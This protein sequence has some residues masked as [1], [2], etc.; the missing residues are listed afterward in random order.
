MVQGKRILLIIAGGIAAYKSLELIRRLGERG[1]SVRAI[2]TRAGAQFV[3]PL[4]VSSLTRERVFTDLFSLT[5]EAEI[6]HIELSRSADLIVVAPATADIMA[7]MATGLADDLAT[8]ALLATDKPVLIAPAMNVRMWT[9]PATQRNLSTLLQSNVT[10]VGPNDGDMACGEYG[11]GRMA[12]PEEIVAAIEALWG[13]RPS[14]SLK[15]C[16]VIITA[17][18]THEP[19]DPVR[20]IANRSSG[21]Q[22]YALAAAAIERGAETILIS[23]PTALPAPSGART[24]RVATAEE[25]QRAAEKELPADI[26]IFAAAVAD[27]RIANVSSEKIKKTGATKVPSLLLAENPDVLAHIAR[28]A[29]R[30]RLVVGFAAETENV[31]ANGKAKLKRKGADLIIANDVSAKSGVMGGTRNRVHVISADGV[32]SWPD[33]SKA[34]VAARLMDRFAQ[35]LA[36]LRKAAE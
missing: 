17:G 30:P 33:L 26:A 34:E 23:G 11:A 13:D 35:L 22:G 20:Y 29:K 32:D 21:R 16:K 25:M 19:I 3:T 1:V 4:S 8:T 7:K 24:I 6:G 10:V 5:D 12:E 2:L 28:H 15:G 31:V 27:W 18:P 9:H 36:G 14:L